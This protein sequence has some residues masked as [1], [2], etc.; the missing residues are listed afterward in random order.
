MESSLVSV[1]IPA[2]NRA[3]LVE[4]TLDSILN[5]TYTNW[6]CI[7][8]DDGSTD[9]TLDVLTKRA[10][11]DA[12][13]RV[14]QRPASR[15][16]GAN[17]CRNIGIENSQGDYIIFFDSDDL[18]TPNHIAF[19]LEKIKESGLDFVIA[20]TVFFNGSDNSMDTCYRFTN[21]EISAENFVLKKAKWLTPDTCIKQNIA[22]K[23]RFNEQLK[24]G[25]EFNYNLKLLL[26]T[27]R[28]ALYDEVVTL[29]RQHEGSIRSKIDHDKVLMNQGTLNAHLY[30]YHDVR[31]IAPAALRSRLVSSCIE[32]N[33]ESPKQLVYDKAL[34]YRAV[35]Y[36]YGVHGLLYFFIADRYKKSDVG[37][38][39]NWSYKFNQ[40]LMKLTTG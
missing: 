35:F 8:T 24:S 16:K 7:I 30:T 3:D 32:L 37:R 18:M 27:T 40:K 34:M 17:T 10:T 36:E 1:I 14:F 13:I 31:G 23:I 15:T 25:Q 6:E 38:L 28:A 29:R 19:K 9:N 4:E 11:Q 5:Q 39:K 26:Q 33:Y 22:S 2:Y 12:R 20:K 21:N